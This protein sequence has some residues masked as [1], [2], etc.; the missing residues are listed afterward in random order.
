ME[1]F[2]EPLERLVLTFQIESLPTDRVAWLFWL[3]L[4]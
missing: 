3:A 2:L 4:F 1:E